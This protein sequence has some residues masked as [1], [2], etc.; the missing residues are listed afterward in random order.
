MIFA[1]DGQPILDEG[2]KGKMLQAKANRAQS[3]IKQIL[4]EE[5][6]DLIGELVYRP[7]GIGCRVV[8]VEKNFKKPLPDLP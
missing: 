7:Q 3:K 6:L 1:P 2:E 5:G 8:Y 4:D